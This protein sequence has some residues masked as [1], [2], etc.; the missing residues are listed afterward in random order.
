MSSNL[1]PGVTDKMIDDHFGGEEECRWHPWDEDERGP[2]PGGPCPDCEAA[3]EAYEDDAYDR[4][5]DD[6]M[7]RERE[8]DR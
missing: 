2:Y 3:R 1:P 7:E 4:W 6:Q 5:R 8:R